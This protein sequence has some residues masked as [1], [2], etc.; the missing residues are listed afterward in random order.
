MGEKNVLSREIERYFLILL[1]RKSIRFYARFFVI[2]N[3][4]IVAEKKN[5]N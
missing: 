5:Y 3:F 4:I 1:F 2:V